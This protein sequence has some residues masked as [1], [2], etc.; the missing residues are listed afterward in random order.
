LQPNYHDL[1]RTGIIL[2]H[3]RLSELS[4]KYRFLKNN[5]FNFHHKTQRGKRWTYAEKNISYAGK[6]SSA[7]YVFFI[8]KEMFVNKTIA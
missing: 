5:T 2:R 8:I 7:G 1:R 3:D 6:I 4:F